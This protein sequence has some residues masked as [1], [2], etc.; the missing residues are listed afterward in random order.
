[1]APTPK[2]APPMAEATMGPDVATTVAAA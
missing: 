1:V 2:T